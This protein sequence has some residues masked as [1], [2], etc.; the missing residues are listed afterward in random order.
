MATSKLITEGG[1]PVAHFDLDA[2]VNEAREEYFTFTFKGEVFTMLPPEEA[3]WQVTAKLGGE[4]GDMAA[5]V[6]ELLGDD[7]ER[8]SKHKLSSTALGKLI[9]QCQEFY[10]V[11]PGE[12][13][14]SAR[15]SRSTRKR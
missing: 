1:E 4:G 5:F 15:S 7:W 8:F 9:E 12:S 11:T 13:R 2:I 14:R 6:A 10:G 3:D